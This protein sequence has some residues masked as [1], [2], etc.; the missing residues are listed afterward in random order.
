MKIIIPF[1][2]IL[3][4]IGLFLF[5]I[6]PNRRTITDLDTR[7]VGINED[8]VKIEELQE[9]NKKQRDQFNKIEKTDREFLEKLLPDG[10]DNVRLFIDIEDMASEYGARPKNINVSRPSETQK[11]GVASGEGDFGSITLS[12]SVTMTFEDFQR[13]IAD[14]ERSLRLVDFVSISFAASDKDRY[15][16]SVSLQ[17]YWLK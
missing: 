2:L 5:F 10:I 15:E 12:F 7:L 11:G 8:L 16:Y 6:Q 3:L 14:L 13:F 9:I 1:F 17:T 4:S